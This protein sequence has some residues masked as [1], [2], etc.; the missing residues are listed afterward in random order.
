MSKNNTFL[1][2][3]KALV[4]FVKTLIGFFKG[5]KEQESIERYRIYDGTV[6]DIEEGYDRIDRKKE[7]KR[8]QTKN[9]KSEKKR[10]EN[11]QKRLDN[12]F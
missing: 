8:K 10:L 2:V 5:R 7:R 12:M 1:D 9:V 4:N 3:V 11:I 6:N